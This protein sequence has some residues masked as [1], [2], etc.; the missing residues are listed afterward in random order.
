MPA[1]RDRTAIR[2]AARE[3]AGI[4]E[5]REGQEDAIRA[6]L[7][8]DGLAVLASGTGKTAVYETAA[9]LLGGPTVVVSPTLSL[10]RD[11]VAALREHGHTAA[12]LNS[13]RGEAGQRTVLESFAAGATSFL[14]LAPEQLVKEDV[15][16]VL[17]RAGVT[18]VVVDEAHCVSE[19]GHDFRPAYSSI[20]AAVERLGHPRV[21]ALTATASPRVRRDIVDHLG[22]R[23][24]AIV[25]RE[26]DRPNIWLGAQLFSEESARDAALVEAVLAE[27]GAAIVYAPTRRRCETLA[28]ALRDAGREALVYHA[29]LRVADRRAAQ[30]AF[31]GGTAQLVVATNAFG[32]GVDRPDVRAVFHAGPATSV[33]EYY[34]EVGRAGRDREA[35]RGTLFFRTEDFALGRYFRSG[36]G[37]SPADLVAVVRA[38]RAGGPR[39]QARLAADTGLSRNRVGAAVGALAAGG[40]LRS[41]RSGV[42]LTAEARDDPA[43]VV[44]RALAERDRR[45]EFDRTRVDMM[46]AYAETA[47]CR[48]RVVLELLGEEHPEPCGHCDNCDAGSSAASGDRP[49]PVGAT[50]AHTEWGNGI[51]SHYEGE[52]IVVLF[53]ERGY[54]TLDLEVVADRNLLTGVPA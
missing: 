40:A 21:L 34:Q 44:D 53:A 15:A 20:G 24:P 10:Q 32:M 33:D 8:T 47:D 51:V 9:A 41:R 1:P 49:Y 14:L 16:E 13:A 23:D 48:R 29:G 42:E 17:G 11:Q 35:S 28:D 50:V 19:W 30:D 37:V 5:L 31:L 25:V 18:L 46:R 36:G 12:A 43:A 2:A 45:R 39:A 54:R 7:E 26:A 4:S 27:P 6:V 22:L 38:L 3:A 52:R